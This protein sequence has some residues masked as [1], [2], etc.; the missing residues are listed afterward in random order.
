MNGLDILIV[1]GVIIAASVG[2]M[3]GLVR[4]ALLLVVFYFATV[5]AIQYYSSVGEMLGWVFPTDVAPRASLGFIMVFAVGVLFLGWVAR[6][7]YP[8]TRILAFGLADNVAGGALGL[9]TGATLV[10]VLTTGLRFAV[11]VP[12]PSYE[13]HRAAL[14]GLAH[15][16]LLMPMVGSYAPM[17]YSTL[18]PWFPSG[19]PAILAL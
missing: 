14:D 9:L 4:Q 16:S 5:L 3:Q 17:L 15:T 13:V 19:M 10:C 2:Y 12:W 6:R 1:V 7:V 18:T 11:A 8:A